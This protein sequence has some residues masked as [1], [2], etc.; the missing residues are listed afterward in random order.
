MRQRHP[1][2][3]PESIAEEDQ[4][5]F[6]AHVVC[7]KLAPECKQITPAGD[8][9]GFVTDFLFVLCDPK[10]KRCFQTLHSYI[11]GL[12]RSPDFHAAQTRKARTRSSGHS[13]RDIPIEDL[14]LP[15]NQT[16]W[17]SD[18]AHNPFKRNAFDCEDLMTQLLTFPSLRHRA[19]RLGRFGWIRTR[20]QM[21]GVC[22]A[23]RQVAN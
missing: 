21:A 4:P 23:Q 19:L 12:R 11:D 9:T 22:T 1:W 2:V 14:Y 5:Y 18:Q 7:D 3:A 20:N 17:D 13:W 15:R 6:S 10:G 16:P 8:I